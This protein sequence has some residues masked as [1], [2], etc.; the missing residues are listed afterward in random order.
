EAEDYVSLG[1][2]KGNIGDQ[3]YQLP[4]GIQAEDYQYALIWCEQFS[5]LF[6]SAE[7]Q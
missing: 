4:D 7:L 1:E 2:L 5:V 3:N 6:G